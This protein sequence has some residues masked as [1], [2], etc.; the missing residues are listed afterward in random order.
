VECGGVRYL[1]A[2]I[3]SFQ[4]AVHFDT[5]PPFHSLFNIQCWYNWQAIQ[6]STVWDTKPNYSSITRYGIR[7]FSVLLPFPALLTA[8][9]QYVYSR[10]GETLTVYNPKD[11]SLIVEG[12]EAA[13][14]QDVDLAVE[15]ATKAYKI[16]RKTSGAER[17]KC[18]MKMAD[19][20]EKETERLAKFETMCMGQ[21]ISVAM[22]IVAF[23]PGIWRYYAGFCDKIEGESFPE[24]GDARVKIT[25]Y[26]P[27]GVCAGIGVHPL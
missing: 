21:P 5:K 4:N 1:G 3:V 24:D 16:W 14:E 20:I 12:I 22:K 6:G 2:H 7:I 27:Y 26:M 23:S 25:Q 17:A 13:G 18:I 15:A 11:D 10:S 9:V 8:L 19:L